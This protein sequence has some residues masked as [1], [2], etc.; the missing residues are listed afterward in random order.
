MAFLIVI[1]YKCSHYMYPEA[2]SNCHA[3]SSATPSRWCVYQFRH[4]GLRRKYRALYQFTKPNLPRFLYL[5][6]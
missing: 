6:S 4:P 5:F 2:D 1:D 3:F